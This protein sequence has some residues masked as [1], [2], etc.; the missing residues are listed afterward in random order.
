MA[1][2]ADG[3]GATAMA[4]RSFPVGASCFKT[5]AS[6]IVV[7]SLRGGRGHACRLV[8][9][10]DCIGDKARSLHLFDESPQIFRAARSTLRR[11]HGLLDFHEMAIHDP[12]LRMLCRVG[13]KW[14]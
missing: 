13:N 2:C 9:A 6:A 7:V 8:G 12:H 1:N 5:A 3:D 10:L 14:L 4:S 11:A